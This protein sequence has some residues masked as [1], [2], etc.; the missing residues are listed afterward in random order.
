M[1]CTK[2]QTHYH[3]PLTQQQGATTLIMSVIL[4]VSISLTTL[5]TARS[6]VIALRLDANEFRAKQAFEAAEAGLN[7]GL[8]YVLNNGADQNNDNAIDTL[9]GYTFSSGNGSSYSVTLTDTS[10]SGDFTQIL[11]T[12]VGLSDDGTGRRTLSQELTLSKT[13]SLAPN[14]ALT[15]HGNVHVQGSANA[16]TNLETNNTIWSG[17]NVTFGGA[18]S[19]ETSSG[20]CSAL[21]CSDV[22]AGSSTGDPALAAISDEAFFQNFF[23]MSRAQTRARADLMVSGDPSDP[24]A[25]YNFTNISASVSGVTGAF[26]WVDG[27]AQINGGIQIGTPTEPVVMVIDGNA[28]LGGNVTIYGLVY[29]SNDWK[30]GNGNLH[31][32]GA[33]IIEGDYESAGNPNTRFDST[34]LAAT[35]TIGRMTPVAGSW[36]DF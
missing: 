20:N 28:H 13:L 4:L 22:N 9:P 8:T 32:V 14:S 27:S 30:H 16:I 12:A 18:G 35:N 31:I 15:S 2:N 34:V 26:I 21:P 6:S 5:F 36:K 3:Q 7:H 29:I 1:I 11:V 25:G 33:A 19:T 23:G 17:G 24:T 10:S